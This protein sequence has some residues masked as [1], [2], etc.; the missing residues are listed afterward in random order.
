VDGS[1]TTTAITGSACNNNGTCLSNSS[2]IVSF[3]YSGGYSTHTFALEKDVTSPSAFTLSSPANN[4]STS[5]SQPTLS[6]SASSDSESGLSHYQLYIDNSLDTNNISGTSV[7][8]ANALSC[9]AHS[10]YVKAVD[11]AGNST[12]SNTFNLTMVCAGTP[13]WLLNQINQNQSPA[14]DNIADDGIAPSSDNKAIEDKDGASDK[15]IIEQIIGLIKIIVQE[16]SEIVKAD[17]NIILS[18]IGLKRDL[19]LEKI[20]VKNY[21]RPLTGQAGDKTEYSITNFIAYGTPTTLRLGRGERAGVVNSYKSSFNKLPTAQSEWE[22]IIKIANGRW[23][24]ETSQKTEQNASAAFRKIYLREPDG[25][26]INDNAAIT[27]IAYGLRPIDRNLDSEKKAIQIFKNI[28]G[29]NPFSATAWDVV[30]AIAYSG[31]TR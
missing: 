9:A 14:A 21:V 30:R 3:T 4:S 27:V 24:S 6:W 17:V 10:W 11:N 15:N 23:P 25:N 18:K 13:M 19:N 7:T 26:N 22:D 16:A 20:A 12:D 31:A 1:A 2:G 28:Y 8:P 29:Y 5:N